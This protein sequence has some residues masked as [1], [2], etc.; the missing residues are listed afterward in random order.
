MTE[1]S[2]FSILHCHSFVVFQFRFQITKS[3]KIAW[4]DIITRD[5]LGSTPKR[6]SLKAI[7][8]GSA[9]AWFRQN[10]LSA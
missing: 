10:A 2:S 3:Q 7:N 4:S 6:A 5:K 1:R 8:R 9:K